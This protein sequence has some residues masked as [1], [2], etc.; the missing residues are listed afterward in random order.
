MK[1]SI[2]AVNGVF[3][4]NIMLCMRLLMFCVCVS[5]FCMMIPM[6]DDPY[7]CHN[8]YNDEYNSSNKTKHE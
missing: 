8:D 4:N 5:A 1:S 2:L 6:H 3:A 7:A